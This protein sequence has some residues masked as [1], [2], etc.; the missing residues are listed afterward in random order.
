PGADAAALRAALE[1]RDLVPRRLGAPGL[2]D[3][4]V[5]CR[6]RVFRSGDVC[7]SAEA[8]RVLVVVVVSS[9]FGGPYPK[10]AT[11]PVAWDLRSGV[12]GV[13]FK[14]LPVIGAQAD[15]R[16]TRASERARK[17]LKPLGEV[18]PP[19]IVSPREKE[20]KNGPGSLRG[21][22]VLR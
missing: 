17:L 7:L 4:L 19:K 15:Q 12:L 9:R 8:S 22:H 20:T 1:G 13:L 14:G 5:D 2:A 21:R 3:E 18:K 10:N 6:H 11:T 16:R